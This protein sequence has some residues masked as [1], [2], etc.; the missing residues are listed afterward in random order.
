[1]KIHRQKVLDKYN[2]HCA[3]CGCELTL[4]TMCVDHIIP[5]RNFGFGAI[6]EIP[7]YTVND[8]KN[9]NPSCQQCN[10]YKSSYNVEQF[11]AELLTLHTRIA[12]PFINRLGEKYGIV[13]INSFDGK[14]YFEQLESDLWQQ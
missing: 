7:E 10:Y 5:K 1:M 6:T 14:F 12:K 9:L 4:K 8:F 2:G 11:R 13:I 3:Y